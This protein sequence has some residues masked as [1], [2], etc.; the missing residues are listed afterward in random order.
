MT[1]FVMPAFDPALL[2]PSV[3]FGLSDTLPW[4]GRMRAANPVLRDPFGMHH[5]FTH[6]EVQQALA[7]PGTF[8]SDPSHVMPQAA[9]ELSAGMLAVMDPPAHTKVR[10]IA[11]AAF[12]PKRVKDLNERISGIAEEL[13]D[14]A[15]EDEFDFVTA[16]SQY[17]PLVVVSELLGI[18]KTDL[19][20]F[21]TWTEQLLQV[22]VPNPNDAAEM[23][24]ALQAALFGPL[25]QMQQYMSGLCAELRA[26]PRDGFISDLLQAEVDGE[27]LA[28][29]EAVN[30][31]IQLLQAGHITSAS[32]LA[33]S[34]LKL[35]ENPEIEA[36]LRA[37][38]AL[39][40][41]AVDEVL[42][43]TPPVPRLQRFTT[44][45]TE[46]GGVQIPAKSMVFLS[47]LSAN[48]DEAEFTDP[49]TF[50]IDRGASRNLTFGHGIHYCFGAALAKT[51][52][53]LGLAALLDRYSAIE[54][55]TD[56]PVEFYESELFTPKSVRVRV[57][58]A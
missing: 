8:S 5:V 29:H 14:A 19:P 35:A 25:V 10:R 18:P 1:E 7:D 54:V 41:A 21:I 27:R 50:D 23:D 47:L 12:T 22:T 31:A 55:V 13:L 56:E 43:F 16:F 39:I 4:L 6:A 48:H 36:R 33:N 20:Q 37:D 51:E 53:K 34:V 44:K 49:D 28:D 58:R 42:R 26:N 24:A 17:L 46:L 2:P 40:P 57:K 52:A 32:V 38:H 15:P 11:S 30:L 45:D 9:A 3:R